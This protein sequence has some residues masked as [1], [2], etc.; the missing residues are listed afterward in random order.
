MV[1]YRNTDFVNTSLRD[2]GVSVV[3]TP[4]TTT[5][6][7]NGDEIRT[8]GTNETITVV[9]HKNKPDYSQL[10]EGLFQ[11]VTGYVMTAPTQTIN[12]NDIITYN[13]VSYRILSV[14]PRG[15]AGDILIYKYCEIESI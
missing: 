4:V 8:S 7:G 2:W 15:P 5:F 12:R 14:T 3:R 1:I 9:L 10:E 11:K 13:N 6:T